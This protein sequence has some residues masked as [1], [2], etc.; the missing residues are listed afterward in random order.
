MRTLLP[1]YVIRFSILQE[2]RCTP[3]ND[4]TLE[5][6]IGRLTAFELS[7]FDNFK[8]ENVE[9]YFKAKLSLK[10]PNEKKKKKKKTC[11]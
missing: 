4:L 5:E 11:F 8:I 1:I 2:L 3:S 9:S 6:L 10:E 7:N